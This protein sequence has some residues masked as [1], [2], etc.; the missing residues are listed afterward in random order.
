MIRKTF[1]LL[2]WLSLATSPGLAIM[3]I[4]HLNVSQHDWNALLNNGVFTTRII[5]LLSAVVILFA[6]LITV[7]TYVQGMRIR[8]NP[9]HY[10]EPQSLL[11]VCGVALASFLSLGSKSAETTQPDRPVGIDVQSVITPV[12][13]GTAAF[14]A[15]RRSQI[16]T[17]SAGV[18]VVVDRSSDAG[19]TSSET[20]EPTS[21]SVLQDVVQSVDST[22]PWEVIVHVFGYPYA[23][24]TKGQVVEFRKKKALELLTWLS[25]NRDRPRRS[26]ARTAMWETDIS[27]SSFATIVSDMRRGL[28]E[29][30][31]RIPARQWAP[32]TFND[33]IVLSPFVVT[34]AELLADSLKRFQHDQTNGDE[35]ISLLEN[36]RDLP[37][38]GTQFSWPDVDGSTTRIVILGAHAAREAAYWAYERKHWSAVTTAVTAGLRLLPGDEELLDLQR[39]M[40]QSSDRRLH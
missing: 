19:L 35:L 8:N 25:I 16:R 32:P 28:S 23:A 2:T 4:V 20:H 15:V 33:E 17:P 24:N 14:H 21:C 27:D 7:I 1:A 3:R 12:M 18:A 5:Q 30:C 9:W 11:P 6:W 38:A 40:L 13:A 29:V 22:R 31:P 34:D 26:A 39:L 10:V 36:I 37:F